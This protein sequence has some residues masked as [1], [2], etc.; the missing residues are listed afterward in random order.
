M[1]ADGL[2]DILIAK[3]IL[4]F[5]PERGDKA[6]QKYRGALLDGMQA[7]SISLRLLQKGIAVERTREVVG[8]NADINPGHVN[9]VTLGKTS[10]DFTRAFDMLAQTLRQS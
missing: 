5:Q 1:P 2:Q 9:V 3:A 10:P 8:G 6:V 4:A 7:Q